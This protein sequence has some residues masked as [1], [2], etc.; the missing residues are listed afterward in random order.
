MS[1]ATMRHRT[2][3]RVAR[4]RTHALREGITVGL[5]GAAI[6]MLWLFIVDLAAGVPLRTPALLGAAL[7]DG[8]RSEVVTPT[9]RLVVGYTAVHLAGFVALGLGVAGLFALAER[10]K[11]VLALIFMLGC[12]LAVV[13][14]AMVYLLAQWLGQAVTPAIFL[15]GHILGAAAMVGALAYFHGR[16]MRRMPEA[17]D[18]E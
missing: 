6:V 7:F 1:E 13:F 4:R 8:A 9:A 18:G 12:C 2:S 5:I 11:R 17:L 10:E 15:A 3:P 14:L 16:L